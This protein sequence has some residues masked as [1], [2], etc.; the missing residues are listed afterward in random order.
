MKVIRI[1]YKR[2]YV[3]T[4]LRSVSNMV[5]P[6][7]FVLCIVYSA[8]VCCS[9]FDGYSVAII[10]SYVSNTLKTSHTVAFTCTSTGKKILVAMYI[11]IHTLEWD[12]FTR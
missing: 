1:S 7:Q 11:Y 9:A 8:L 10:T 5:Y 4:F 6:K 12:D 2:V 3:H